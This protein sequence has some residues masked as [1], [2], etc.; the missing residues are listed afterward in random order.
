MPQTCHSWRRWCNLSRACLDTLRGFCRMHKQKSPRRRQVPHGRYQRAGGL[1]E[2]LASE[3]RD[4][5]ICQSSHETI[6]MQE[7]NVQLHKSDS[8]NM[9]MVQ[10]A[11][12]TLRV[13]ACG[14]FKQCPQECPVRPP[15][16]CHPTRTL[17]IK[18]VRLTTINQRKFRSCRSGCVE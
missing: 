7:G 1:R 5:H 12:G 17:L 15:Q 8:D 9:H 11:H 2:D 4:L 3:S 18:K 13:Q 6:N 16:T 10:R 14:I